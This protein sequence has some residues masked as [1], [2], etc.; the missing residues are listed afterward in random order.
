MKLFKHLLTLLCVPQV[1]FDTGVG[2]SLGGPAG[3]GRSLRSNVRPVYTSAGP[4]LVARKPARKGR[5]TNAQGEKEI[6]I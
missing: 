4:C 6:E 1:E 2:G 3:R 5:R